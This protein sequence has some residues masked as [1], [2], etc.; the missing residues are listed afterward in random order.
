M[1]SNNTYGHVDSELRFACNDLPDL[2]ILSKTDAFVR[3][4]HVNNGKADLVW[5]SKVVD[6]NLNPEFADFFK[7]QYRFEIV[8]LYKVE[9]YHF[10][11]NNMSK[12]IGEAEFKIAEIV[13]IDILIRDLI[14]TRNDK[15]KGAKV[16]SS[17]LD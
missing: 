3:V 9:V 10:V 17:N 15:Y 8:Q 13:A 5:E 14:D 4:Y 7:V 6:N 16:I 2:D 12:Y 11:K 1:A